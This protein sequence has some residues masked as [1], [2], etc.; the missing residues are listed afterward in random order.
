MDHSTTSLLPLFLISI[1]AFITPIFTS[2]F[3][4]K[5]KFHLPVVVGEIICGIIIGKSFLGIIGNTNSIPWLDFLYLFGFTYLMFLSGLEVDINALL[6]TTKRE[7]P[8]TA[9][10]KKTPSLLKLGVLYFI[11]TLCLS[12]GCSLLL[13]GLGYIHNIIMMTLI[14]STTS[15]SIV[16]PVLKE[17]LLAKTDYGQ[18]ILVSALIAD[19]L[20]M[21][22]ITIFIAF[23]SSDKSTFN[24]LFLFVI[25]A[26][27]ILVYR[28]HLSKTFDGVINYILKLKPLI[29]NL[30]NQTTQI[31]VRGAIALMV[32]FIAASQAMGIEV[33]LGAF[34]AGIVTTLVLGEE[35]T[36]QLE[37]KLD[38]IG[39]GFFIPIFFIGVGINLDLGIFFNSQSVWILLLLLIIAAFLIKIIPSLIFKFKFT[40]KESLSAGILL[41]SRLSLII[42]ASTI[43]LKE[44]FI[45]E[46]VNAA[47]VMV[48]VVSCVI[49]PMLF[50]KVR[51]KSNIQT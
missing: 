40:L 37:M 39:Y 25:L 27:I 32:I 30:S 5:T 6:N 29:K 4:A 1:L 19:F 46:E 43:G 15:V 16:V 45:T 10:H 51:L 7:N 21:T 18:T 11:L 13:K 24:L 35:K 17:K 41:S 22:L 49:A 42:A 9:T 12:F 26:M 48:A 14:L 23:S 38:A 44:G 33:I 31:K 2:W 20:T 28:L 3:S 47:I 50:D 34:L 8:I 36:E